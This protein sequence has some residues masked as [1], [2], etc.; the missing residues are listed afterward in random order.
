[1]RTNTFYFIAIPFIIG[2]FLAENCTFLKASPWDSCRVAGLLLLLSL[3]PF[4]TLRKKS[5][6]FAI[7]LFFCLGVITACTKELSYRQFPQPAFVSDWLSALKNR[8]RSLPLRSENCRSLLLALIAG[9]KNGLTT[10]IR[11][12]F[13][14][15]GAAHLLALSGLHLGIISG[16]LNGILR[17]FGNTR[18]AILIR[19]ITVVIF[20]GLYTLI[21][22][23]GASL[24]RAFLFILFSSTALQFPHRRSNPATI[25]LLSACIQLSFSPASVNT[26]SF[27]LSYLACIGIICIY[28]KLQS[29]FSGTGITLKIWQSTALSLSCQACTAPLVWWRFKSLPKYFLLTNLLSLPV[30]EMLIVSSVAAITASALGFSPKALCMVCDFLGNLLIR[31][32]RLI[33]SIP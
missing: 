13:R 27:Q 14:N 32:I 16:A 6:L 5:G 9:D 8:I 22:G 26:L 30:C 3:I 33:A 19:S 11:D 2:I 25:L 21:C 1:M 29:W 31:I 7:P 24:T 18:R 15:S 12:A 23:A 28:P 4:C 20:S 17:I 10:D